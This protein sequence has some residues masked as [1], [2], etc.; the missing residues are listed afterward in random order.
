MEKK[1][2]VSCTEYKNCKD[3]YASWIFF[4]IG[5]VATISLRIVTVLMNINPAYGRAAWY[6]GVAGFFAFFVY[7][8]RIAR[9]RAKLI[10]RSDLIK[11][12]NRRSGLAKEDY[13]IMGAILCGLSS[14]KEMANFFFIFGLSAV[15]LVLAVY[16][17][18][19]K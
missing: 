17:D 6:T 9:A 19:V 13:D 7:K 2:C 11:K 4:V 8:F 14:K 1:K 5:L 15:A 12:M 16:F 18:F 3:S 10:E